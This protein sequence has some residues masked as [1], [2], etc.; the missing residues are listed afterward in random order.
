MPTVNLWSGVAVAVQ[1]ALASAITINSIT[2]ASPAVVTY[3]GTDPT[4]GDYIKITAQGMTQ[5]NGR[6][7]RIANVNSGSNTLELE[8]EDSSSYDTFTSGSFEVVT[9][10]TSLTVA[11]DINAS[12]GDY[13]FVDTTTIHDTV[14]SQIPGAASPATYTMN[15]IWDAADAGLVALKSAADNKAQR[16]IRF[17]FS[18][19]AKMVFNGYVGATLL[20][21]GAA[22]DKVTT[23]VTLTAFGRPKTYS[24]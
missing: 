5:V 19:G 17:T 1:S 22:Q 21:T 18:S 9:F 2:K 7:F 11:T 16:C 10:G 15:C 8:S 3:T 13:D 24:S 6:V 23:S 14:R 4:N 12:G 20:P